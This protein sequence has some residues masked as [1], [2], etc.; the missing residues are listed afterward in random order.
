MIACGLPPGGAA[1]EFETAPLSPEEAP[2]SPKKGTLS[3]AL[4]S[5][6]LR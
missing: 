2:P 4:I 1:Q 5:I 3:N 6:R